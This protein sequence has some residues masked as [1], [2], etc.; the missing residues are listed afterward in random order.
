MLRGGGIP[1][2]T[3][4]TLCVKNI[5][6]EQ[7]QDIGAPNNSDAILIKTYNEL[8]AAQNAVYVLTIE[9][10]FKFIYLF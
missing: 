3:H 6:K 9:S 8:D 5:K 1:D 7:K 10:F 4:D 2:S